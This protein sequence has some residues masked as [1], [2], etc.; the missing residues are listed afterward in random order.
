MEHYLR[1]HARAVATLAV[2]PGVDVSPATVRNILADL[3]AQ[4]LV[5]RRIP[6]PAAYPRIAGCGSSSTAC[7]TYARWT[8]SVE[9]LRDG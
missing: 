8:S 7:C 3:E 2:Q 5:V 4:G 6:P 9:L 1:G